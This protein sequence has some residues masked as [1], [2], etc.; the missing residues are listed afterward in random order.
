MKKRQIQ[1]AFTLAEVLITLVIIGIVAAL[2]I[3]TLISNYQE[4]QTVTKL[5]K[6]FSVIN[7]AYALAKIEYGDIT[8]W[9]FSGNSQV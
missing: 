6:S 8:S 2:T 7:N 3:P 4:R 9:G 5:I 1:K